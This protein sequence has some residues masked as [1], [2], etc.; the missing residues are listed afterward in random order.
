MSP[1]SILSLPPLDPTLSTPPLRRTALNTTITAS[2]T[3]EH[4]YL[5]DCSSSSNNVRNRSGEIS[6][7]TQPATVKLGEIRAER[8]V[9]EMRAERVV[10]EMHLSKSF[11]GAR[12][13]ELEENE[14]VIAELKPTI[15]QTRTKV[16]RKEEFFVSSNIIVAFSPE[17]FRVSGSTVTRINSQ[18]WA[19]C[20][21]KPV[22]KG[23]HRL[24]I[25]TQ[26]NCVMIGVLDAA[27]YPE[28][29]TRE[30]YRSSKAA[31]MNTSNGYLGSAYKPVGQNTPPQEGQE[32]SAEA[33]L[34][35]RTLHFFIDG[36]QQP[37]HFIN[38][39]VP[40]VFAIDACVKDVPIEITFWGE[41]QS[42]VTFEGTGYNLG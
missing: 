39:P 16:A 33:D 27:E 41:T 1:P 10:K 34:E 40:L 12:L 35:K 7:T 14:R 36:V 5:L 29:L 23:I 38:I 19:G 20:F 3:D 28:Y 31:M 18:S 30:V 26:A 4:L 2:E 32:W 37:H 24:S 22:S 42:H 8:V 13:N 11:Q 25:R 15:Q 6:L 21:T 17:H 9:K